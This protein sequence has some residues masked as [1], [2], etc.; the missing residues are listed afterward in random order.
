M[1]GIM[2]P[3]FVSSQASY[4]VASITCQALDR[5]TAPEGVAKLS[6]TYVL[7]H[8]DVGFLSLAIERKNASPPTVD[9]LRRG[10]DLEQPF[11]ARG[12][13]FDHFSGQ[14]IC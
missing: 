4:D 5:Q 10:V 9:V 7:R 8:V 2:N 14:L 13:I 6:R 11:L 3:H 1:Q 12:G